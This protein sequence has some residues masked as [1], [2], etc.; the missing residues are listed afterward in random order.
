MNEK[1]LEE[2]VRQVLASVTQAPAASAAPAPAQA[3]AKLDPKADYPLATKRPEL[4][5]SPTGKKLGDITLDNVLSGA[6]T[7]D[8]VR[9]TPETLRMQ[10][11][12][13]DGVGRVQF[14]ANLRRAAELT[15]IPDARILEIYNALRPYRST[16]AELLAIAD[17]LD[18]KFAAKINAAFVREAADVYERRNRLKAE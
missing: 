18:N 15:A 4:L 2:L 6:V 17:E 9:I 11:E 5:K 12:I 16:K 14:A 3:C 8:D 10:A 1:M 7:A 13:A